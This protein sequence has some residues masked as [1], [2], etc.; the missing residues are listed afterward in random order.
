MLQDLAHWPVDNVAGADRPGGVTETF[1]DTARLRVASVTKPL[2][3]S[4]VLVAV[5]EGAVELD[6][7]A[8]PPGATVA[9]LLSHASGL[10]FDS[11]EQIA[12]VASQRIYSSAGFE[13]LAETVEQATG[14]AFPD[15]LT[16]AVAE[17]LGMS[18]TTLDGPA[19]HGATSCVDDL[20]TTPMTCCA[21]AWLRGDCPQCTVGVVSRARR[22]RSRLRAS[23]AL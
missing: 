14:I 7:P 15:Y 17:P 4:A 23:P 21:R 11:R 19:G 12:P 8:G 6:T 13:V 2:V 22:L 3:A 16:A 5:E 20:A 10:A 1:G 18:T 9:H